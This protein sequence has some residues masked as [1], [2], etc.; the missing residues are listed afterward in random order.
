MIVRCKPPF[1]AHPRLIRATAV[2]TAGAALLLMSTSQPALASVKATPASGTPQL[3]PTGTTEQI[4]Q[5]VQ[6]GQVMYAVGS[7]TSISQ[8]GTTFARNNI[9]SFSASSPYAVTS[10]N[11][12]V[13][14]V[15]N[16]IAF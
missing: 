12:N 10:W 11:P 9:F 6:C 16:S 15:V 3:P 13:N 4:R 2:A 8:N 5:L 1:S 14:G 7:F